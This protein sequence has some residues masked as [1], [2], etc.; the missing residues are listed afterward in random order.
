MKKSIYRRIEKYGQSI[1]E[2]WV[3]ERGRIK[4]LYKRSKD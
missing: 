2:V 1:N 4:P 3:R